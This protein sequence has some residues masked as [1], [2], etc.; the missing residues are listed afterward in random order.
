MK[1][2]N[3][4]VCALAQVRG[5]IRRVASFVRAASCELYDV[6]RCFQINFVNI[7]NGYTIHNS[8]VCALACIGDRAAGTRF[9][10]SIGAKYLV[11]RTV[12]CSHHI[13]G[14]LKNAS[15]KHVLIS[16]CTIL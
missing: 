11:A 10:F 4:Q 5:A 12:Q 3:S 6:Q 1:I 9:K 16:R 15:R 8:Q 7:R 13:D 14:R 2:H